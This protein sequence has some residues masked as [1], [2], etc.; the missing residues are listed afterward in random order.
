MHDKRIK[1]SVGE[2]KIARY[3]A[4]YAPEEARFVHVGNAAGP[5]L[6]VLIE[7]ASVSGKNIHVDAVNALE[8]EAQDEHCYLPGSL[9]F[10]FIEEDASYRNMLQRI[11]VWYRAVKAGGIITGS[12]YS[13]YNSGVMGAVHQCF[14]P[15]CAVFPDVWAVHRGE[16]ADPHS[17]HQPYYP[18]VVSDLPLDR[19]MFDGWRERLRKGGEALDADLILDAPRFGEQA[20][21]PLLFLAEAERSDVRHSA[22]VALASFL[23]S[24]E[25]SSVSR[26][27]LLFALKRLLKDQ[28]FAIRQVAQEAFRYGQT[29][30]MLGGKNGVAEAQALLKAISSPKIAVRMD[31]LKMLKTLP[32]ESVLSAYRPVP[33]TVLVDCLNQAEFP[34][35]IALSPHR[36]CVVTVALPG[37]E[38]SLDKF[39]AG[40]MTDDTQDSVSVV[41]FTPSQNK[42]CY[43]IGRNHGATVLPCRWI[44]PVE[45]S[46]RGVLCSV[47]KAVF[48][49]KY[50]CLD[51]H[52]HIRGPLGTIF[53]A[54]DVLDEYTILVNRSPHSVP[55]L[56]DRYQLATVVTHDCDAETDD[57][58]FLVGTTGG[59]DLRPVQ[60]DTRAFA[61]SRAA[62]LELD[63]SIRRLQ[64]FASAW[65]GGASR[66]AAKR[67]EAIIAYAVGMM[68]FA[69]EMRPGSPLQTL[70][71]PDIH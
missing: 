14:G 41:V 51:L 34:A 35:P 63:R 37:E 5:S 61:G 62:L 18:V 8:Y 21:E 57:V 12:G 10:V 47:A 48:A 27:A 58:S 9:D 24:A 45:T 68:E 17:D 54:L 26:D 44:E 49:D 1:V 50:L 64:P 60:A 66:S 56:S 71:S 2:E 19:A 29:R 40:A 15:D 52:T 32:R 39:L 6:D 33:T 46:G 31:A 55:D 67:E 69:T 20:V 65:I 42:Q 30:K 36:C 13:A 28:D 25:I 70:A 59:L 22:C 53:D 7:A 4:D 3:A 16:D 43:E 23:T 11:P 38:H